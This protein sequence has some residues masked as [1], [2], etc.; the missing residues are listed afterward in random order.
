MHE[1]E[2]ER[3]S[4]E[5]ERARERASKRERACMGVLRIEIEGGAGGREGGNACVLH[6]LWT[7]DLDSKVEHR[8]RSTGMN[9]HLKSCHS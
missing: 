1:R 4:Q 9:V 8:L 5:R 7:D 2:R 6:C 3:E